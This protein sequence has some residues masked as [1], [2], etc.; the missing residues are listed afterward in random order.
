[1]GACQ[2]TCPDHASASR[3]PG[4]RLGYVTPVLYQTIGPGTDA[5]T[6]GA[7]G[8]TDVVEGNNT[9]APAGGYSA[10]PGYDAVSGWGTPNGVKLAEAL[11]RAL[12]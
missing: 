2:S 12:S 11:A 7:L 6:V 5:A 4:H 8:C 10:G 9:T 1:V 3:G